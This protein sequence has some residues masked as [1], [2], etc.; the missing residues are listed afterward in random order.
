M[1]NILIL[2]IMEMKMIKYELLRGSDSN[3]SGLVNEYLSKGWFLYGHP[4]QTGNKID[5]SYGSNEYTMQ[6]AQA[7]VKGI[8]N[9]MS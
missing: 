4:F 5:C 6:I 9:E 3:L 7:V 8:E 2:S 1:V